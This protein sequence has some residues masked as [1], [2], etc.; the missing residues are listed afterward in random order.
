[1]PPQSLTLPTHP[2]SP[3]TMSAEDADYLVEEVSTED[4]FWKVSSLLSETS[5]AAGGVDVVLSRDEVRHQ[6]GDEGSV[7]VITRRHGCGGAVEWS[8]TDDN[9][10]RSLNSIR[11]R[12]DPPLT[13]EEEAEVAALQ[14]RFEA[15]IAKGTQ[16]DLSFSS[17]VA[18]MPYSLVMSVNPGL[19]SKKGRKAL[20]TLATLPICGQAESLNMPAVWKQACVIPVDRVLGIRKVGSLLATKAL[21][22][23]YT[24]VL[25]EATPHFLQGDTAD[26]DVDSVGFVVRSAEGCPLKEG[27]MVTSLNEGAVENST[28]RHLREQGGRVQVDAHPH[29]TISAIQLL[30][31][32]GGFAAMLKAFEDASSPFLKHKKDSSFVVRKRVEQ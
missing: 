21:K 31:T 24:K 9:R 4:D 27:S 3:G 15:F 2:S 11:E 23:H 5:V 7:F 30:P 8:R 13:P 32:S 20:E 1:M 28:L 26:F 22:I 29:G 6:E 14:P 12:G 25:A 17:Y 16:V 18:W 19:L 10:L